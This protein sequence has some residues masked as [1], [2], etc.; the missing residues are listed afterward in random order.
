MRPKLIFS[1]IAAFWAVMMFL[2][3]RSEFGL[4]SGGLSGSLSPE[5]VWEKMLTA[6]DT[7]SL[8]ILFRGKRVGMG[9]WASGVK[10]DT[11]VPGANEDGLAG[12]GRVERVTG[13]SVELDGNASIT[14]LT[15]TLRF[16][17]GGSFETNFH[18]SQWEVRLAL[19]PLQLEL[20][21]S[22]DSGE[23][24]MNYHD[25]YQ[26]I[27]RQFTREQLRRPEALLAD[28]A[29][30]S[31]LLIAGQ[32][33]SAMAANGVSTNAASGS[34]IRWEAGFDWM[35]LGHGSLRVYLLRGK[36]GAN[37]Q[38]K[39]WVSRAGE[40]LRA[41]LPYQIVIVNTELPRLKPRS[42]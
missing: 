4:G 16:S 29:G 14:T 40:I 27:Q 10:Q 17:L 12:E 1:G 5:V 34:A 24:A 36:L 26:A 30:P 18:W 7:S 3:V 25:G 22:V 41:E 42:A 15:N 37:L 38:I 23:V 9:R 35:D 39:L 19:K 6:Q 32:V 31:A 33:K 11:A 8:E 21:G 28:L 13:Y 2:L 20:S